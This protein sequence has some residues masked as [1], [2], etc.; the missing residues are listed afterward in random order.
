MHLTVTSRVISERELEDT[1]IV[2]RNASSNPTPRGRGWIERQV[3][4]GSS[5]YLI[6]KNQ[7]AYPG[8]PLFYWQQRR[9]WR[10][11]DGRSGEQITKSSSEN[12]SKLSSLRQ[13][14]CC[15]QDSNRERSCSFPAP[16]SSL[17]QLPKTSESDSVARKEEPTAPHF[18]S[19]PRWMLFVGRSNHPDWFFTSLTKTRRTEQVATE[20]SLRLFVKNGHSLTNL[21]S[22]SLVV[23]LR[24]IYDPNLQATTDT[25]LVIQSL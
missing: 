23:W 3:E 14:A 5:Q 16:G 17:P 9:K 22:C 13:A 25:Y 21:S 18:N 15:W 20:G 12:P 24:S 19:R 4:T 10:S 2:V 7:R 6:K 1:K 8:L 11:Q